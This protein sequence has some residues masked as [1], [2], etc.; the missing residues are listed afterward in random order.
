MSTINGELEILISTERKNEY[1][2]S[3]FETNTQTE[4]CTRRLLLIIV[5]LFST[6]FVHVQTRIGQSVV[7]MM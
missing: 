2:W 3:Q 5:Q 7:A 4:K 1:L 6:R